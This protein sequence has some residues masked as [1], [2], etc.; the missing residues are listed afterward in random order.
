MVA[1]CQDQKGL[2]PE[3]FPETGE[4]EGLT[5][6]ENLEKDPMEDTEE[7][8]THQSQEPEHLK[9][10]GESG[11]LEFRGVSDSLPMAW[12][13]VPSITIPWAGVGGVGSPNQPSPSSPFQS[14]S[15]SRLLGS[16]V[17]GKFSATSALGF[18]EVGTTENAPC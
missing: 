11:N 1:P 18:N 14:V 4:M 9:G 2:L 15:S 8:R 3:T 7:T 12:G 13:W 16:L 5:P 10:P 6:K 17:D